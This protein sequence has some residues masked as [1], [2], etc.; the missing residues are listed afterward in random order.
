[1]TLLAVERI[2]LFSTR[3]PWWCAALAVGLPLTY[4]GLSAASSDEGL[5]VAGAM[6]GHQFGLMVV[7]VMAVL[8]ITTCLLYTSPSP[9]DS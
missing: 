1:M 4:T 5:S 3:S 6:A 7:L 2:K 9:R 8:A